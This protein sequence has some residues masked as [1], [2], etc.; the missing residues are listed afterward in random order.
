MLAADAA[1]PPD[2]ARGLVLSGR[3]AKASADSAVRAS[4]RSPAGRPRPPRRRAGRPHRRRVRLGTH[5]PGVARG[6]GPH[7]R[8]RLDRHPAR[9]RR[10]RRTQRRGARRSRHAG[11]PGRPRRARPPRPRG[12]PARRRH[13]PRRAAGGLSHPGQ[14]ADPRRRHPLGEAAGRPHRPSRQ[15]ADRRGLA[16]RVAARCRPGAARRRCRARLRLRFRPSVAARW[17]RRWCARCAA[18]AVRCRC[19]S[20][21]ATSCCAIAG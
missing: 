3:M 19:W 15:R 5:R 8:V 20:I 16:C 6:A 17:S 11:G 4:H 18:A 7:P 1:R 13:P 9:R 14:D 2:G 12:V 10:Q 21:R